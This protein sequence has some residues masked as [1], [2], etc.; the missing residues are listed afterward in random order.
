[1]SLLADSLLWLSSLLITLRNPSF[2]LMFDLGC[3]MWIHVLSM[4][5]KWH[6]HSSRLRLNNAKHTFEVAARLRLWLILNKRGNHLADS[7]LYPSDHSKLKAL[8]YVLCL[9]LS[10]S[11][12][13]SI[14]YRWRPYRRF[15]NSFGDNDLNWTFRKKGAILDCAT[16]TKF[17]FAKNVWWG[18]QVSSLPPNFMT[19]FAYKWCKYKLNDAATQNL[20]K[21]HY[22][23][24][25]RGYFR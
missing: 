13:V 10:W 18:H 12:A 24:V 15:F 2:W 17:N 7:F 14:F 21:F 19:L 8:R 9:G 11:H 4:V 22:W 25:C 20:T 3:V 16:K 5:I 23:K 6:K 1:M